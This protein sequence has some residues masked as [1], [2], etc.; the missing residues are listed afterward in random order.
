MW[1][2][3]TRLKT[4]WP[5]VKKQAALLVRDAEARH[6]LVDEVML[7]FNDPAKMSALGE[8]IKNLA[9]PDATDK[10]VEEIYRIA[11]RNRLT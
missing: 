6:Q 1:L 11:N 10:I 8:R 9:L 3:T 7:L 2:R 4:H 5:L